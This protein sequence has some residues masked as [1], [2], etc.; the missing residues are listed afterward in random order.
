MKKP[1]AKHK[2]PTKMPVMA[3]IV[4]D[5]IPSSLRHYDFGGPAYDLVAGSPFKNPGR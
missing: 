5:M 1:T 4:S 2:N 3:M